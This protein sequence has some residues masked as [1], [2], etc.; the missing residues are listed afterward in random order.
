[1]EIEEQYLSKHGS[2]KNKDGT[3]EYINPEP[4]TT[5]NNGGDTNYYAIKREWITL[6]DVIEEREMNFAQGNI[7][8]ASFTLNTGRHSGTNY[9]RELNKIKYYCDRELKRIKSGN[10]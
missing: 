9:E 7:L 1:M 10:V 4:D 6:N 2:K 8:K 5:K 3:V